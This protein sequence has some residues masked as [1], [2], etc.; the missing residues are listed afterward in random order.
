VSWTPLS[1]GGQ[2]CRGSLLLRVSEPVEV[3]AG[4]DDGAV[5]RHSV[6]DRGAK[7]RVGEYL[8]PAREGLVRRDRDG[9][10]FFSFSE[11]LEA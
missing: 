2:C 5:E 11:A 9:V 1:A 10:V 4:F 8:G 3:G 7:S 6:D